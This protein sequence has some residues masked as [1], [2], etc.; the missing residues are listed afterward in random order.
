LPKYS[1]PAIGFRVFLKN[2]RGIIGGAVINYYELKIA[3]RLVEN[4]ANSFI[5]KLRGI[6]SRH[7]DANSRFSRHNL[8]YTFGY[9]ES[10]MFVR[11]AND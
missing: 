3:E 1:Y 2:R 10:F 8:K 11:V 5:E 9:L 7:H 4:T 6:E